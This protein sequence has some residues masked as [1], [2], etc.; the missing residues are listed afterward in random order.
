MEYHSADVAEVIGNGRVRAYEIELHPD[1]GDIPEQ[2]VKDLN[3][4]FSEIV[5]LTVNKEG[6]KKVRKRVEQR[7]LADSKMGA[8]SH[9]EELM[10]RIRFDLIKNYIKLG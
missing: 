3:L 7:L 1:S 9:A 5:V 2:V 10:A 6:L 4:G 8:R